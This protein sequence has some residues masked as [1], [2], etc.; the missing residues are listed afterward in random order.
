MWLPW[1]FWSWGEGSS[2]GLSSSFKLLLLEC[3]LLY[4][5]LVVFRFFWD[6]RIKE[7]I[8]AIKSKLTILHKIF[9]AIL[10]IYGRCCMKC[11]I[12]LSFYFFFGWTR[13]QDD[14]RSFTWMSL[15]G[16]W[17]SWWF[18]WIAA[19]FKNISSIR[20]RWEQ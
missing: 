6:H 4:F 17:T 20:G 2:Y 15:G 9:H 16:R 12:S 7:Y 11:L 14:F 1:S 18:L 5:I 3:K 13:Y 10:G 19:S 8:A